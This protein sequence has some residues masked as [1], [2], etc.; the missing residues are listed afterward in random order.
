MYHVLKNSEDN[1]VKTNLAPFIVNNFYCNYLSGNYMENNLL[2]IITL[3]L[4]DEVD[5]LKSIEQVDHFL[6]NTKCG[7]L[8]EE[9]QKMPDIQIYFQ[10]VIFKTV[11]KIE[12]NFSFREISLNISD[13]Q[14]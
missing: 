9:L 8:L 4:K 5:K 12:R 6:D 2:Y 13:K 1:V 7:Y 11:E 3:M 10:K 14:K